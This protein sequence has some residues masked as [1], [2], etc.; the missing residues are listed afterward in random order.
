MSGYLDWPRYSR[1]TWI[2][3]AILIVL[4][5]LL[6]WVGRGPDAGAC[7]GR[8]VAVAPP[9]A[10]APTAPVKSAGR[11]DL[12]SRGDKITL[13]GIVPD[14]AAHDSLLAAAT[15]AYGAGNVVDRLTIDASA[16]QWA[17]LSKPEGLFGWLKYGFRSA[18]T[19]RSDG[20]VVAGVVPDQAAHD[21]R[22]EA[23]RE[24]Y[25]ADTNL[26]DRIVI[27][28]PLATTVAKAED[29]KCGGSIAATINFASGSA[30]ID[31]AGKKLLDAIASCLTGPYEIDG[32]TDSSGD[33]EINLPL[34]KQRAD[35][36]RDYLAGKGVDA[37]N[38]TTEGF[39]AERPIADNATEEGRAKNR[40]IE[41]IKK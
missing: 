37:A 33:D 12:V 14:Q 19:C 16:P 25:G 6:W 34:S 29:V 41:F 31:E 32:H 9:P 35:A 40:R 20:V 36:V 28:A 5:L 30:E 1:A 26:I 24:L 11:L 18:L 7:C 38:L 13:A 17:C 10:A 22:L 23:A 2:V 21:A 8:T 15:V 39:G 4:L 3:A 27:A